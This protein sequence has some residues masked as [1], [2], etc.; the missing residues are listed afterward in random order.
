M[1]PRPFTYGD[2]KTLA[3]KPGFAG[4]ISG[5]CRDN[6]IMEWLPEA[7]WLDSHVHRELHHPEGNPLD[8]TLAC[9]EVADSLDYDAISKTALLFHDIGKAASAGGY[10]RFKHPYHNFLR[11]EERGIPVFDCIAGR[12]RVP[13]E[14]ADVIRYCIRFHMHSHRFQKM[15]KHSV[16][17]I[18][19]SPYYPVLKNVSYADC[20]SRRENF[21]QDEILASFAYAEDLADSFCSWFRD[22]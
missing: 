17:E 11:H 13:D 9:L 6:S 18:V 8:H 1:L 14:D 10:D 20:A 15:E 2:L 21:R 22:S 3:S 7:F 5:M 12:L 19:L 16:L 4:A